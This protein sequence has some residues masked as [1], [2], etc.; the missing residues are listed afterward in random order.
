MTCDLDKKV[1]TAF[2][3]VETSRETMRESL[4]NLALHIKTSVFD[5]GLKRDLLD[6]IVKEKSELVCESVEKDTKQCVENLES[7]RT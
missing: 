1:K 4:K 2:S 7:V 5:E 3:N 6:K